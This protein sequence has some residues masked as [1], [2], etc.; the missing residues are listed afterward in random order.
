MMMQEPRILKMETSSFHPAKKDPEIKFRCEVYQTHKY[1]LFRY[2]EG[3]RG[4]DLINLHRVKESIKEEYLVNPIIINEKWEIIEGQHRFEAVKELNLPVYFI[5]IPGYGIKQTYKLNTIG[6]KWDALSFADS[7]A[8]MGNPHYQVFLQFREKYKF[9]TRGLMAILSGGNSGKW[10]KHLEKFGKGEFVVEDEEAAH[11][12]ARKILD[13]EPYYPGGIHRRS[14]IAA[15]IKLMSHKLY[16]HS[17]ML[18]KLEK[19]PYPIYH[20]P[21]T[22]QYLEVLVKTFNYHRHGEKIS[23]I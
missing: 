19:R 9:D 20:F 15:I 2:L 16:N 1:S 11:E 3:N 18:E 12:M 10:G 7:Y 21:N 8:K 5:Q 14:F 17:Q 23:S 4:L 22:S 13:Y 6:K